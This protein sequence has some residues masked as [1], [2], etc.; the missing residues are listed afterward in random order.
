MICRYSRPEMERIWTAENK[1]QCWL[2]VELAACKAMNKVGIIPNDD[3][4]IILEK[5]NFEAVRIDEIEK[6]TKH[7]VIAFLTNVAEYVGESSRWVH[8]G[9]T[10]SDVLDTGLAM[11]CRQAGLLLLQSMKDLCVVL[12][13]RALEY[14]DTLC[15]GRTHGVHAEPTSFGLKFVLWY[16]EMQRNIARM[17][18]AVER[19]AVGKLSGAVGNFA[20]ISPDIEE[21]TCKYLGLK[22]ANIST[23]VIQRDV[24]AEFMAVIA[25]IGTTLEKMAVEIRHLQRTEVLEVEE[26][27]AKGQK[28]SS[29]MP[30]K[31]NP[32]TSEQI[33]GLA[34][35]L[36]ANAQAA[37]ENNVLWH[38]RDISNSSVERIIF[39]D[40][41]VLL[42][43]MLFKMVSLIE[44]L[45]VYPENIKRNLELTHGLV[46]SQELLLKLAEKGMSR[47][48]AYA[49][50]QRHAMECWESKVPLRE[51][52][53]KD[54]EIVK[55]LSG[56]ELDE[57]F[58]YQ[59]YLRYV[60][61]IFER[62]GV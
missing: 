60:G 47:E 39:P 45:M 38:E 57:V 24:H 2:E 49:L 48:G 17:E 42:H 20:H 35:L 50:V 58:S 46:F 37:L 19:I 59:R 5:A 51:L 53:E 1:Y 44:Y 41:C 36:R 56:D 14:K 10:S 30:H 8:Y 15:I 25:I 11:Q 21:L 3:L 23:Q 4:K 7:D 6:E 31:K 29:A 54:D 28:G 26:S 40:S 27:F 43:Y 33:T 62:C 52:I 16:D 13:N 32:V 18:E 9:L 22:S 55:V 61:C 34:R 12:K